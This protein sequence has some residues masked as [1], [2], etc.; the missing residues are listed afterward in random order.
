MFNKDEFKELGNFFKHG[1]VAKGFNFPYTSQD[2]A[3]G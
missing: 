2:K 1:K 3:V